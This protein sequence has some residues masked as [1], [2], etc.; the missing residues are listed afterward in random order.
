[1]KAQAIS[2]FGDCSVFETIDLPKPEIKPGYVLIRVVATSVNPVD[3]KVR[4]GKYSHISPAFPAVLH[5]DVAGI[6]EEIWPE[7]TEFSVGDEVYGCAGGFLDES[8][9]LA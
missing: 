5:S 4:A 6:I 1:M 7:V 8:G 3:C 2:S 9:A